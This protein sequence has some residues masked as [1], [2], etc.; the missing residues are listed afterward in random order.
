MQAYG[1]LT[2]EEASALIDA[3]Q[4]P[5]FIKACLITTWRQARR[6]AKLTSITVLVSENGELTIIFHVDE[7]EFDGD[8]NKYEYH[9]SLDA[10]N[11]AAFLKALPYHYEDPKT[12]G[13]EW[14]VNH[15]DCD[16]RSLDLMERGYKW[17][18]M[19]NVT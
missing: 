5:N 8:G 9:Y 4:A 11:T 1:R 3:E 19:E 13:E 14:L 16:G 2:E 7:S 15:I 18:C 10:E 17:D 12:T 6:K